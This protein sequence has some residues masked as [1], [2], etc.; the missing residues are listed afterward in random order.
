MIGAFTCV[1]PI[2]IRTR[3]AAQSQR[4]NGGR[5]VEMSNVIIVRCLRMC[6]TIITV[7][8]VGL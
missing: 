3:D 8:C 4:L 1:L 7:R 2:R 5:D 6:C